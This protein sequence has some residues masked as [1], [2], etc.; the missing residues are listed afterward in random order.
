MKKHLA[1]FLGTALLACSPE[2]TSPDPG[3][4]TE[5]GILVVHAASYPLAFFATRIGGSAVLVE[6][7]KN[8]V[9]TRS[10]TDFK[11]TSDGVGQQFFR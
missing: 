1:A 5:T 2:P 4:A 3:E 9:N 11:F 6:F 10:I 8:S 7:P